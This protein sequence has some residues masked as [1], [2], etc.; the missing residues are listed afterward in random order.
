MKNTVKIERI[1]KYGREKIIYLQ[2]RR[3]TKRF[4]KR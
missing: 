4:Y 1:I 2:F 3:K